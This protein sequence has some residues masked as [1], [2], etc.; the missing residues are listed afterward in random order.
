MAISKPE[1]EK[2]IQTPENGKVAFAKL[3]AGNDK[4]IRDKG[5]KKLKR[6]LLARS[7]SNFGEFRLW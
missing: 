7:T 2:Q 6:W 3:L 1:S 4:K 5:L